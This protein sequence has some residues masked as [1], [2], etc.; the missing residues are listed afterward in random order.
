[1]IEFHPQ[2]IVIRP[3]ALYAE[4]QNVVDITSLCQALN[5]FLNAPIKPCCESLTV[6]KNREKN[7]IISALKTKREIYRQNHKYLPSPGYES[8]LVSI[9]LS[10]RRQET[11]RNISNH[12]NNFPIKSKQFSTTPS[13]LNYD[14][15]IHEDYV[16]SDANWSSKDASL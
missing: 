14:P 9:F 4:L 1:M 6:K 11:L 16:Y 7:Q 8:I 13:Y 5:S 10:K 15:K 3:T 12:E 2:G